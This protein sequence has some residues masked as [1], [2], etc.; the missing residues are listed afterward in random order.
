MREAQVAVDVPPADVTMTGRL[1]QGGLVAVFGVAAA[2][3]F[4]IAIAQSLLAIALACWAALLLM[5]RDRL[6]VPRFFWPLLAFS[7]VTLVSAAFSPQPLV[8]LA[9][10]KQL[11]LFLVVPL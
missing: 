11:L 9:D 5:R 2:L 10:T 7:G 3:Q 6:E 8:S 1:E 4:S